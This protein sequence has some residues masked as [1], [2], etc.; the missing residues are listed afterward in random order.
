MNNLEHAFHN[1]KQ[2]AIRIE[3]LPTFLIPK[4]AEALRAIRS[5][6]QPDFDFMNGWHS[7][8]DMVTKKGRTSRR[9]RLLSEPPSEYE[10]FELKWG[11]P[12][13]IKHG[14]Q[15]RCIRRNKSEDLFDCWLF[16]GS[17]GFQ[18][19]YDEKG[20]FLGSK[21]LGTTETK[22]LVDWVTSVWTSLPVFTEYVT[23]T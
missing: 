2:D 18:M 16:D 15:I 10:D 5:G 7:R 21:K 11:Y 1:Y 8:L 6:R 9:I 14:E 20:S 4:E 12:S 13:N 17:L 19:L 23:E 22:R 3:V